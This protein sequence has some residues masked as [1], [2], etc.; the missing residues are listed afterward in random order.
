MGGGGLKV[1]VFLGD[2]G[3]GGTGWVKKKDI[4]REK[5]RP[6]AKKEK[7]SISSP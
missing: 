6:E 3:S 1:K 4:E 5:N 2:P 7:I